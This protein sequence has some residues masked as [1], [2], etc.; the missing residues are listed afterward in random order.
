MT[1]NENQII[2]YHLDEI[3]RLNVRVECCQCVNVA[4]GQFQFPIEGAT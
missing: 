2:A 1:A 4:S 3:V